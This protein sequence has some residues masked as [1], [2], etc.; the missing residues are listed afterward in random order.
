[1]KIEFFSAV[2]FTIAIAGCSAIPASS[3]AVQRSGVSDNTDSMGDTGGE[4]LGVTPKSVVLPD[5]SGSHAILSCASKG[6]EY[7][8]LPALPAAGYTEVQID[9]A[10]NNPIAK[11]RDW[12]KNAADVNKLLTNIS[13]NITQSNWNTSGGIAGIFSGSHDRKQYVID[14]MKWRAEPLTDTANTPLG[15]VRLGVGLRLI[16]NITKDDGSASASLFA[17]A[18]NAKSGRVEGSISVELIGMDS[19]ETTQAMPFTVDL[20]EGNVLKVVEALAIVKTKLYDD[21]SKVSP[22]LIA[23]IECAPL[24]QSKGKQ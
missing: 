18:A 24:A 21:A 1:M 22:N 5:G 16:I 4:V 17:L 7:T 20:S 9:P 11:A 3:G 19:K 23:R 14:F 6:V 12:P 15:W 2:I 13:T 8:P 10:T